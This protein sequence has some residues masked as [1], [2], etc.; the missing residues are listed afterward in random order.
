[1]RFGEGERLLLLVLLPLGGLL[2]LRLLDTLRGPLR[3]LGDG[4]DEID[5]PRLGGGPLPLRGEIDREREWRGRRR[6]ERLR[7]RGGGDLLGGLLNRLGGGDRLLGGERLR[8]GLPRPLLGESR[9]GDLLRRGGGE[10]ERLLRGDGGLRRGGGGDTTPRFAGGE[11]GRR[12][13]GGEF[14][15]R[16]GEGSDGGESALWFAGGD[17]LRGGGDGAFLRGDG[18]FVCGGASLSATIITFSLCGAS[19]FSGTGLAGDLGAFWR[20]IS[21]NFTLTTFPST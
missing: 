20:G 14:A 4:E 9:R 13:G 11:S 6:G 18:S 12:R 1:M 15:G 8:I 7:R 19:F 3:G 10:G 5:L 17:R 2:G 21:V 16:F